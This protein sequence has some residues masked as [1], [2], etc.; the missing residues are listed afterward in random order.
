MAYQVL[1]QIPQYDNRDCQRGWVTR[2]V[3]GLPAYE[4]VGMALAKRLQLA[5]EQDDN[6]GD[7]SFYVIDLATNVKVR[8]PVPVMNWGDEDIPF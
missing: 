4:T 3:E 6:G 7:V 8:T 2:E 5:C 1:C